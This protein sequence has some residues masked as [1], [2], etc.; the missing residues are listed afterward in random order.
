MLG[1]EGRYRRQVGHL[2]GQ[3]VRARQRLPVFYAIRALPA[4]PCRRY[5][6]GRLRSGVLQVV[7]ADHAHA[8][9]NEVWQR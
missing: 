8:K 9:S 4:Y 6:E 2:N 5:P 3:A 7:V 1:W